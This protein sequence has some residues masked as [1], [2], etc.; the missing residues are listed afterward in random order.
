MFHLL[1][2]ERDHLTAVLG[3]EG[4]GGEGEGMKESFYDGAEGRGGGTP[5]K[6]GD[7]EDSVMRQLEINYGKLKT[8]RAG[9][10]KGTILHHKI[11][12][13]RGETTL[14]LFKQ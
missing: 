10:S 13:K 3:L 5:K 11:L 9:R 12:S 2:R 1:T 8:H 14:K 7:E 4:R 6:S